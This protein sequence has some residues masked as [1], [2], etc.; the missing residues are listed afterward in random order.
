MGSSGGGGGGASS[1]TTTITHSPYI[2][3]AHKSLLAHITNLRK[4]VGVSAQSPY[5]DYHQIDLNSIL[6]GAGKSI[7]SVATLGNLYENFIL[8]VD[9]NQL[10]VNIYTSLSG[11]VAKHAISSHSAELNYQLNTDI[12]PKLDVGARDIGAV[13]S[14]SYVIA[15][16]N[17]LNTKVRAI[18]KFA[19]DLEMQLITT[20]SNHWKA[21]LQWDTNV[22]EIFKTITE[23]Y[24][25]RH[26]QTEQF[27]TTL[28][29]KHRLWPF[30]V[31]D[32]ERVTIGALAGASQ[33][34]TEVDGDGNDAGRM[35]GGALGGAAMGFM[36]GA[37]E[38]T[39]I[40]GPV[41]GVIGGALGLA[42]GIA[43]N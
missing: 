18:S 2:E 33:S 22:V 21:R 7:G 35:I 40:S 20:A 15:R 8:D 10:Y 25:T 19:A 37:M 3:S 39:A 34:K 29:A 1:Q 4:T 26:M 31:A 5:I 24:I 9:I 23:Q 16:S 36:Y 6:F 42:M 28:L 13:L 38:G 32:H 27:N 30:I 41:G 43:G 12:L 11:T 17:I 14:S